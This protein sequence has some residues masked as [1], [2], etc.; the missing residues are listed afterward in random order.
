[1]TSETRTTLTFFGAGL[2]AAAL[3]LGADLSWH[4]VIRTLF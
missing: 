1:M 2:V 3:V 4:D